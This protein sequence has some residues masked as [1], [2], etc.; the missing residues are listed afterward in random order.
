MKT[1]ASKQKTFLCAHC[2][3]PVFCGQRNVTGNFS[4]HYV[5]VSGER[6]QGF[7]LHWSCEEKRNA[8]QEKETFDEK[9]V[10]SVTGRTN[11]FVFHREL[12]QL[13][14]DQRKEQNKKN[15]KK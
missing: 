4:G 10:A 11:W 15:R 8:K 14:L 12:K 13:R 9:V 5:I 1:I 2:F 3:R 6:K 7:Y